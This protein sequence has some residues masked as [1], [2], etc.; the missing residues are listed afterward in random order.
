M[1]IMKTV[2]AKLVRLLTVAALLASSGKLFASESSPVQL[3]VDWPK[4]M[5]QQDLVWERL[6]A[7][8]YEGAFVGNGLLGAIIF[9]DNRQTNSLRF[10]IGRTDIYDHREGGQAAYERSRLPIGQLLLT[11]AGKITGAK[12]RT[13]LWNAETRG[14]S[15]PP[16][17]KLNG[18]VLCPAVK[19]SWWLN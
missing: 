5:A 13:D 17:V 1:T 4:F 10:E 19:R 11:P 16:P 9:R 8:Y 2:S 7:E 3:A 18:A 15:S 14:N 12:L 6:P